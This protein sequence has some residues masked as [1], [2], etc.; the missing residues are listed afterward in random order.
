MV[1]LF[2]KDDVDARVEGSAVLGG[3][4]NLDGGLVA[5][6]DVCA[7]GQR[8]LSETDGA[9]VG[10][11]G[12]AEDLE[13]MDHGVAHVGRAAV[14]VGAGIGAKAKIDLKER[15]EVAAEP[16]GLEG[17]GAAANGPVGAVL[18]DS[19]AAAWIHPLHSIGICLVGNEV[20]A[21]PAGISDDG[22][23][24]GE[25]SEGEA[26][27]KIELHDGKRELS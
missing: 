13:G 10:I 5:G 11:V 22:V 4:D 25:A 7:D 6:L 16:A 15:G 19:R 20:I 18:G 23:C 27:E 2:N 26:D 8:N 1:A 21:A 12:R 9:G 14:N 24:G 3:L 17:D